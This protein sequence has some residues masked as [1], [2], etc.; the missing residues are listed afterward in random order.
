M[1]ALSPLEAVRTCYSVST[2]RGLQQLLQRRALSQAH[3]EAALEHASAWAL[4]VSQCGALR[5][6]RIAAE[7]AY[8]EHAGTNMM[9]LKSSLRKKKQERQHVGRSATPVVIFPLS[10][11]AQAG[12]LA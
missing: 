8:G 2:Y 12:L 3:N 7:R 10:F 5:G 6:T 4:V 1:A 11:G 9:Q